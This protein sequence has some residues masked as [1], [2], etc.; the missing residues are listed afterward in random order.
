MQNII[1]SGVFGRIFEIL[2]AF[3][4]NPVFAAETVKD[5]DS[6]P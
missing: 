6:D 2:F 5:P 3:S 1:F 4:L